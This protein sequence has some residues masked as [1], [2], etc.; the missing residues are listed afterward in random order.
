[1][2]DICMK[3]ADTKTQPHASTTF[4]HGCWMWLPSPRVM[5]VMFFETNMQKG[6]R[7]FRAQGWGAGP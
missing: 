3:M 6:D 7:P 4:L 5:I 2:S 1:M